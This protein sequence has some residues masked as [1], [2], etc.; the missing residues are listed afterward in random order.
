MTSA[1][2]TLADRIMSAEEV[3]EHLRVPVKDVKKAWREGRLLGSRFS[4]GYRFRL[5]AVEKFLGEEEQ[6]WRERNIAVHGSTKNPDEP[7]STST[8]TTKPMD[9][10]G[11]EALALEIA[12]ELTKPSGSSSSNV[13]ELK[14]RRPANL[15]TATR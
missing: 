14:S 10:S 12:S 4:G 7:P 9:G 3:A 5:S 13:R 1:G 2:A 11:D 8:G 15:P 6:R